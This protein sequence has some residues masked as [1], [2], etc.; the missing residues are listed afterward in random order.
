MK[1]SIP[2]FKKKSIDPS[3]HGVD[4]RV[5]SGSYWLTLTD[6]AYLFPTLHSARPSGQREISHGASIDT[7]GIGGHYK[8]GIFPLEIWLLNITVIPWTAA[9]RNISSLNIY[10]LDLRSAVEQKSR[11][12]QLEYGV[13][14]ASVL[15][16]VVRRPSHRKDSYMPW[17]EGGNMKKQ[18]SGGLNLGEGDKG[19]L[20][21]FFFF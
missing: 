3:P 15:H 18:G 8:L 1:Q 5:E 10:C 7:T 12:E 16:G 11:T 21:F 17:P 19:Q 9:R 13:K 6:R 4:I 2:R 20:C 14:G